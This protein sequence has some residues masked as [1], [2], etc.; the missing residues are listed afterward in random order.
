MSRSAFIA[1]AIA[2]SVMTATLSSRQGAAAV[3]VLESERLDN[4]LEVLILPEPGREVAAVLV[5]YLTG[6]RDEEPGTFGY[7]HLFEHLMFSGT[8]DVPDW[9]EAVAALGGRSQSMTT[10]NWTAF[11]T[12]I[13]LLHVNRI[14]ALE[15]DRMR[16]L[17][18]DR[19]A[20]AQAL[21]DIRLE[22]VARGRQ[23]LTVGDLGDLLRP[24]AFPDHPFAL[25]PKA[26]DLDPADPELC[27]AFYSRHYGPDRAMLVVAGGVVADSILAAA[28]HHFGP[29]PSTGAVRSPLPA[30]PPLPAERRSLVPGRGSPTV[31][32]GYRVPRLGEADATLSR[33]VHAVINQGAAPILR[34][35]VRDGGPPAVAVSAALDQSIGLL[36]VAARLDPGADPDT[37]LD[38]LINALPLVVEAIDEQLIATSREQLRLADATLSGTVSA[39]AAAAAQDYMAKSES[40]GDESVPGAHLVALGSDDCTR[41]ARTYLQPE[42]AVSLVFAPAPGESTSAEPE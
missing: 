19:A 26:T 8:Q 22:Q 27:R 12:D 35:A 28:R 25:A 36:T 38:R 23:P 40:P 37:A 3:P 18:L 10:S 41:F 17:K 29:I 21:D 39:R 42:A 20:V 9:D 30:L 7:A 15:A 31:A 5:W 2:A 14:I 24:L 16:G 34:E 33:L 4:G 32:A 11:E 6:S 1:L 13:S